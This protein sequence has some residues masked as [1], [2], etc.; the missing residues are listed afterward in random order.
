MSNVFLVI[1]LTVSGAIGLAM[2]RVLPRHRRSPIMVVAVSAVVAFCGIFIL[3]DLLPSG[4]T[5]WM[6]RWEPMGGFELQDDA[7]TVWQVTVSS[8]DRYASAT[9]PPG[10]MPQ[11]RLVARQEERIATCVYP[12][13]FRF[14][15]TVSATS[16]A[17]YV[18]QTQYTPRLR[19][20]IRDGCW[21]SDTVPG[22]CR[23]PS[24][25][26]KEQYSADASRIDAPQ[27]QPPADA[28]APPPENGD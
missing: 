4:Y 18:E 17:L 20:R 11:V 24:E 1:V 22:R 2:Q 14:G 15:A 8:R 10:P 3:P 13:R 12:T 5:Y 16:D 9:T 6:A 23:W 26:V 25:G 28:P 7:R 21:E 27:D 19:F